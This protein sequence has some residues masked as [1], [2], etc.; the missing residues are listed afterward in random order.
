MSAFSRRTGKQLKESRFPRSLFF[1]CLLSL[2]LASGLHTGII[3]LMNEM[4]LNEVIQSI[5]PV[6]YWTAAA[7]GLTI[8]IRYKIQQTYDLPTKQ[9]AQ[10]MDMVA[11]GDFSVYVP[12]LHTA[13]KADYMDEMIQDFNRMVEELGSI[14]TLKTDFFSNV[15]HE[16]KTPLAVIQNSAE[17]LKIQGHTPQQQQEYVDTIIQASKRLSGLITDILKINRLEKQTISPEVCPYNICSQLGECALQFESSWEEKE[18]DFIADMEDQA[19]IN[20]DPNLME[21]VWNNLLSN[22]FKFTPNGGTIT[23]SQVSNESDVTV[24]I[25]DSGCGMEAETVRHI[26]DKFYQGDG[27]HATK[28][29]GLGLAIVKR[30]LE[31]MDF[32]ITVVSHPNKGTT[33]TLRI[34]LFKPDQNSATER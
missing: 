18:I 14:E 26:F 7:V 3:V 23:L 8:F 19:T 34:P 1:T 4:K 33:F 30:V 16:I 11:N 22:A 6:V 17:M 2:L 25:S 29:N 32:P 5:I 27:S 21:L 13:D 20:A 10:A 24:S 28:G 12:V 15:S 31:L 9:L